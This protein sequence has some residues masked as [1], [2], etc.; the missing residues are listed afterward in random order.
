[1]ARVYHE[2]IVSAID[3]GTTKICVL[4]AQQLDGESI[5]ILGIGKAPSDG[6][7]KGV[8]VDIGKTIHS[9]KAAIQ[10]AELMAGIQIESAG[11]GIAGG[12]IESVNS[13]GVVPVKQGEIRATD[14]ANVL[15]AAQAIPIPEGMR[16]LHV[17]PQYFVIDGHQQ[18]VDPI[19]MHGVRL[20]VQAH[21]IMGAITSVQ[22]LVKCCEQ[23]GVTVSDI[24]LEQ[25]ASADAVLSPDERQLGV[26]MLDIGGGTSD[27]ALYQNGSIRHTMVLPVGGNHFTNDLA[28]G[29]RTTIQDA[30]RLKHQYGLVTSEVL[31]ADEILEADMVH[32]LNPSINSGQVMLRNESKDRSLLSS[33]KHSGRTAEKQFVQTSQLLRILQPRAQEIFDLIHREIV[34]KN[35]TRFMSTGLVLTGGGSLLKG[36]PELAHEIFNLPVRIGLPRIEFA[37]PESLNS[38]IYATGYG[39]LVH[40]VKRSEQ[41]K[42]QATDGPLAQRVFDRMKSWVSDFF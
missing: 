29:L 22:D 32:S 20:E 13:H 2:K 41:Q 15:A 34:A 1:M 31:I 23:A 26:A 24:I 27:L 8:V 5:D 4:I 19:G 42:M 9:I 11:V 33:S 7:R 10:E 40:M 12:H 14:V 25:L 17:L 6:L 39:L 28:I 38:P 21:I 18:V 37:M 16:I 35:L 3:V 36:M 30:V